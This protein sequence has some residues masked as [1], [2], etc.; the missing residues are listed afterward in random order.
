MRITREQLLEA[1]GIPDNG[2]DGVIVTL[3]DFIDIKSPV[4]EIDDLSGNPLKWSKFIPADDKEYG[5]FTVPDLKK[6]CLHVWEPLDM[7][8]N[9]CRCGKTKH[10]TMHDLNPRKTPVNCKHPEWHSY[11]PDGDICLS[12]GEKVPPRKEDVD[13]VAEWLFDEGLIVGNDWADRDITAEKLLKAGLSAG[14][15]K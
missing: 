10:I 13:R 6:E 1:L 5:A 2:A 8:H 4:I 9:Q 12:C 11:T 7:F 14:R 3:P 15:L